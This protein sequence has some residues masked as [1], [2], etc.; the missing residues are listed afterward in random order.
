MTGEIKE[1][2]QDAINIL[3]IC[4]KT[5]Y[6]IDNKVLDEKEIVT[7]MIALDNLVSDLENTIKE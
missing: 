3:K 2:I 6:M 7:V 4:K 1:T 5:L